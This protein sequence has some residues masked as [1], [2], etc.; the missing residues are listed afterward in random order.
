MGKIMPVYQLSDEIIFPDPTQA[1]DGLLA[2]GGDLS[3]ERLL[4]AY[5]MGIF[6]WPNDDYLMWFSPNP[7]TV[8]FPEKLKVRKSLRQSIR[9]KGFV[10]RFDTNFKQVVKACAEINRKHESGTWIS[11]KMQ[12]AYTKLHELGYA[13]SVEIYQNRRLVG[14]LYGVSLGKAFYGESMF[15]KVS[16]ASKVALFYLVEFAKRYHIQFIDAQM[17]TQH[18]IS[19]GAEDISQHRFLQHNQKALEYNNMR[20]LWAFNSG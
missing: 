3:A 1:E 5:S 6:P 10:C 19:M 13:H 12:Q 17:R 7:R 9:N 14:G 20:G 4:M 11:A 18:L 2:V 15:A 16:D 8:L